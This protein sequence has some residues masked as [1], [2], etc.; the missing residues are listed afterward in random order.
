MTKHDRSFSNALVSRETTENL[1]EL[2]L[3]NRPRSRSRSSTNEGKTAQAQCKDLLYSPARYPVTVGRSEQECA[4]RMGETGETQR[5][6][7]TQRPKRKQS[8]TDTLLFHVPD[9]QS[10]ARHDGL[11]PRAGS[12][13]SVTAQNPTF[14]QSSITSGTL[15]R[16]HTPNES[17]PRTRDQRPPPPS[18][19]ASVPGA[20]HPMAGML[21]TDRARS[22]RER[23]FVGGEC[24]ACEE[25]LEHTLRGERVLQFSCGHVA[26]EACFYE[27]IRDQDSQY[28]PTC[29]APLGLDSFRGGSI[30][31]LSMFP[32]HAQ[33]PPSKASPL[34]IDDR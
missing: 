16:P 5:R 8:P 20:G 26:H 31:D 2:G 13:L 33:S 11:P 25:L 27:Y 23:T 17:R 1:Y 30:L 22:R 12:A 19:T 7:E 21:D 6:S 29:D 3:L 32:F 24:A 15:G 14:K 18:P 28:C 9:Q 10:R 4:R 34:T